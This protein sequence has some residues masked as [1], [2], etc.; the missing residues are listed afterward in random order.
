MISQSGTFALLPPSIPDSLTVT[1][2]NWIPGLSV[3]ISNP[4]ARISYFGTLVVYSP[5]SNQN[6]GKIYRTNSKNSGVDNINFFYSHY[7][8]VIADVIIKGYDSSSVPAYY[9]TYYDLNFKKGWN[10][11]TETTIS[12]DFTFTK[13]GAFSTEP[14]GGHWIYVSGYNDIF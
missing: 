5:S 13:F 10:N 12:Y 9:M 3:Y 7:I 1:V 6:I 11:I 2:R 8:Y 14:D 4:D